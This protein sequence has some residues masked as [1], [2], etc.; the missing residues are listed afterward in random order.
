PNS[1]PVGQQVAV[2]EPALPV[3]RAA[4]APLQQPLGPLNRIVW[5]NRQ[6]ELATVGQAQVQQYLLLPRRGVGCGRV[7]VGIRTAG[8]WRILA[9]RKSIPVLEK[10]SGIGRVGSGVGEVGSGVGEVSSGVGEVGS[11]IGEVGSGVGEVGSGIEGVGSGVGEVGSGIEDVG[12][13]VEE[14]GSGIEGV[15]SGVR[16][17]GSGIEGVGSG[18]R[19]VGSGVEDVGSGVGEVG[20]GIEGVGSGVGEVDRFRCRAAD[21]VDWSCQHVQRQLVAAAQLVIAVSEESVRQRDTRAADDRLSQFVITGLQGGG[22]RLQRVPDLLA[23]FECRRGVPEFVSLRAQLTVGERLLRVPANSLTA[24]GEIVAARLVYGRERGPPVHRPLHAWLLGKLQKQ[25][26]QQ[27]GIGAFDSLNFSGLAMP[28]FRRTHEENRIWCCILCFRKADRVISA[29]Q[30]ELIEQ[31]ILPE[32]CHAYIRNTLPG[33]MCSCCSKKLQS[34]TS[35]VPQELPA[36]LPYLQIVADLEV[37]PQLTQTTRSQD[38]DSEK[39]CTRCH[40]LVGKGLRHECS[41]SS[42][43]QYLRTLSPTSK[44][45]IAHDVMR[46]KL[47]AAAASGHGSTASISSATGGPPMQL[48]HAS[49][50]NEQRALRT[51]TLVTLKTSLNLSDRQTNM[52]ATIIR[53]AEGSRKAV[54]PG[55]RAALAAAGSIAESFFEMRQ[56][57]FT[58]KS[59][60]GSFTDTTRCSVICPDLQGLLSFICSKRG[61]KLHIMLGV[62]NK[63]LDQLNSAWGDDKA[64]KWAHSAGICREQYHGG[65]LEGP[66]CVR[67]LLKA[68]ELKSNLPSRLQGYAS[69]LMAFDAVRQACFGQQLMSDFCQKIAQLESCCAELKLVPTPKMHAL[70]H[71]VPE[72]CERF[73]SG[74]GTFSEQAVESAHSDFRS[75]WQRFRRPLGH[76]QYAECLLRAVPRTAHAPKPIIADMQSWLCPSDR[77]LRLRACI[78]RGW[79]TPRS[80][81]AALTPAECAAIGDVLRR[82][83]ALR[84]LDWGRVGRVADQVERLRLAQCGDGLASCRLC[85]LR[86]RHRWWRPS[87]RC[88][89]CGYKYCDACAR[90]LPEAGTKRGQSNPARQPGCANCAERVACWRPRAEPGFTSLAYDPRLTASEDACRPPTPEKP[91]LSTNQESPSSP[92]EKMTSLQRSQSQQPIESIWKFQSHLDLQ[93]HFGRVES[94]QHNG[95][96]AGKLNRPRNLAIIR[97]RKSASCSQIGQTAVS[98][99]PP[100]PVGSG[101]PSQGKVAQRGVQ[102]LVLLVRLH[103]PAAVQSQAAERCQAVA[104]ARV[105]QLADADA[106]GAEGAGAAQAGAAVNHQ[107]AGQRHGPLCQGQQ[108]NSRIGRCVIGPAAEP[109]VLNQQGLTAARLLSVLWAEPSVLSRVLPIASSHIKSQESPLKSLLA[110]VQFKQLGGH[111]AVPHPVANVQWKVQLA[112]WPVPLYQPYL[113]GDKAPLSQTGSAHEIRIDIAAIV[114]RHSGSRIRHDAGVAILRY[115]ARLRQLL[116]SGVTSLFVLIRRVGLLAEGFATGAERDAGRRQWRK[117]GAETADC[118]DCADIGVAASAG[119]GAAALG[120]VSTQSAMAAPLGAGQTGRRFVQNQQQKQDGAK[121][122]NQRD[123]PAR[124]HGDVGDIAG[125]GGRR[126]RHTHRP[127]SL[128]PPL[129]NNFNSASEQ[130]PTVLRVEPPLRVDG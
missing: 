45:H 73:N 115:R 44:E 48:R 9:L 11:G 29:A 95:R 71:H 43:L 80:A 121:A 86:L 39:R 13:G 67:L 98:A 118:A 38:R 22:G 23:A 106:Q 41:V 75:T 92:D 60:G 16:E 19:E 2:A 25:Q 116:A 77:Q 62:T 27:S 7:T 74:L 57:K 20:S 49:D 120:L 59:S 66:A 105:Q 72:F 12:S 69:A 94:I 26:Q 63:L 8:V 99:G 53:Q 114:Q 127:A 83:R 31:F 93:S 97:R 117:A 113:S 34:Q 1:N 17:V 40:S 109:Q 82:D 78:A 64:Y 54:Q 50:S 4:G 55:L 128:L 35:P 100:S 15:D 65:C 111:P 108:G 79:S 47:R 18:I 46:E 51:E 21:E 90:P 103:H 101:Q 119:I 110:V 5:L 102:K 76:V 89:D 37:L 129:A 107:Q 112:L 124:C 52:A 91:S 42:K 70:F 6:A 3:G 58:Q 88:S 81:V 30:A 14:V 125:V 85:G 96:R 10:C 28:N 126:L 24:K 56:L 84:L 61:F 36:R 122:S 68:Q 87:G 130:R 123:Q 33:G 104:G 32:F